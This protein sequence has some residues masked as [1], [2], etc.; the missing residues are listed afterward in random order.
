LVWDTKSLGQKINLSPGVVLDH[1]VHIDTKAVFA[2]DFIALW[3]MVDLL[4]LIQPIIQVGFAAATAPDDVPL[5]RLRVLK[6]VC[7]EN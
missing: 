6:L 7:L 2:S 1:L 3:K 4:V 5:V